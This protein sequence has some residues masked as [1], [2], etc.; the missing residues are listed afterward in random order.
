MKK[1][2]NEAF[3]VATFGTKQ[4]KDNNDQEMKKHQVQKTKTSKVIIDFVALKCADSNRDFLVKLKNPCNRS[5]TC[6]SDESVRNLPK[7]IDGAMTQESNNMAKNSLHSKH[8]HEHDH[9]DL[10]KIEAYRVNTITVQSGY[11]LKIR[12]TGKRLGK[13]HR[14]RTESLLMNKSS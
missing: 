14:E 6:Q 1:N 12:N 5:R 8:E 9:P 2:T 10:F 3:T 13:V 7:K 4:K 11:T